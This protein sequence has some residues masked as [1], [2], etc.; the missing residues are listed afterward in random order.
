MHILIVCLVIFKAIFNH[1]HREFILNER[2]EK[3]RCQ[4]AWRCQFGGI[5]RREKRNIIAVIENALNAIYNWIS[6]IQQNSSA[7]NKVW[8]FHQFSADAVYLFLT[9]FNSMPRLNGNIWMSER[10][11][12]ATAWMFLRAHKN[13]FLVCGN[14]VFSRLLIVCYVTTTNR[15]RSS[16]EKREKFQWIKLATN[17]QTH[18]H[19]L[20]DIHNTILHTKKKCTNP[21]TCMYHLFYV[22]YRHMG[23]CPE[24]IIDR[25][26]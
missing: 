11:K 9:V 18:T 19:T 14:L 13:Q 25:R 3:I 21:C 26:I 20:P 12:R 6:F 10:K 24:K 16:Y 5:S 4:D 17:T 1:A 7:N 15:R 23:F 2:F 8:E 22:W